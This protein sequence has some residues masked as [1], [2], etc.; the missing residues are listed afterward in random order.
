MPV[1]GIM[2][3]G[4]GFRAMNAYAGCINALYGAGICDCAMYIAGL[5]GSSW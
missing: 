1:I 4:G 5:S 3:S 2:G